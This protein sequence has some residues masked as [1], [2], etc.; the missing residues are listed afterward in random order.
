MRLVDPGGELLGGHQ[1]EGAPQD[2]PLTT[3]VARAVTGESG[4][5]VDGYRNYLGRMSVGA[6]TASWRNQKPVAWID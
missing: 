3:A 1:P 5:D 4:T 6:W 2:W